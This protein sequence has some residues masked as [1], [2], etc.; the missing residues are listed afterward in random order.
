MSPIFSLFWRWYERH[1][2]LNITLALALFLLQLAHLYW[3]A[4]DVIAN[5][6][7]DQSFFSL[8]GAWQSVIILVDYTE[9]P[10][11]LSTSLIYIHALTKKYSFKNY[12]YLALIASQLL[13]IFWITDEFVIEQF[14][15]VNQSTILPLWLAWM[16]IL[17]DYLEL[18]VIFDTITK[19]TVAVRENNIKKAREA[20]EK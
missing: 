11:L 15:N 16:A 1:L 10:A 13:H 5:K 18:P 8:T 3:L 20:F 12:L 7:V 17:I 14:T 4:A 9:I 2:I 19:L 6:L